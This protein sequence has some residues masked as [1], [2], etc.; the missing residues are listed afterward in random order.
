MSRDFV[1]LSAEKQKG[2]CGFPRK[3][4]GLREDHWH[5]TGRVN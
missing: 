3:P 2:H 5:F 4:K 1:V